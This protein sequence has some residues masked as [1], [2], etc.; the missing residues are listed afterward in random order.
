MCAHS[1]RKKPGSWHA[2]YPRAVLVVR[3]G[4]LALTCLA[5]RLR[6][7][8]SEVGHLI[9]RCGEP[10]SEVIREPRQVGAEGGELGQDLCG[11]QVRPTPSVVLAGLLWSGLSAHVRQGRVSHGGNTSQPRTKGIGTTRVRKDLDS[12]V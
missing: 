10:V 11:R 9:A 3:V 7:P 6:Q 5:G 12:R 8:R 2:P 1:G 4:K